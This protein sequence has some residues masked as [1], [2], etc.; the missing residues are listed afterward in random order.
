MDP[1]NLGPLDIQQYL[2]RADF[3]LNKEVAENSGDPQ[4]VVEE[5]RD[6]LSKGYITGALGGQ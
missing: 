5:M 6:R 3:P 1:G 2:E 4:Q